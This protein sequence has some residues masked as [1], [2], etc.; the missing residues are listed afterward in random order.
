[1]LLDGDARQVEWELVL[2]GREALAL[3]EQ[4]GR[5]GVLPPAQHLLAILQQQPHQSASHLLVLG[6]LFQG[7]AQCLLHRVPATTRHVELGQAQLCL[8]VLGLDLQQ[9]L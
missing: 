4:L 3:L 7:L 9:T 5:P 8:D 2:V 6:V 1:M